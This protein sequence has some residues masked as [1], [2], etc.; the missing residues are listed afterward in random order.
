MRT[1]IPPRETGVLVMRRP[2]GRRMATVSGVLF[3]VFLVPALVALIVAGSVST[4]RDWIG[5][6]GRPETDL[7]RRGQ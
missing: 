6:R 7:E 2:Y 1:I 5:G 4:W 3:W